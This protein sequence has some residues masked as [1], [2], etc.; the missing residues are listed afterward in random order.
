MD[1]L[2]QGRCENC[3]I[4]QLNSL[5]ALS[6]SELK[7]ISDSKTTKS[8]KKGDTIFTEGENLNGVFCVRNGVTKLSK[9]S[10]NGKD[11]IVKLAKK[12]EVLGQRSVIANQKT[13]L[14]AIALKD[15]EVC[16]IPKHK[17]NESI[18]NNIE[19]TKEILLKM[20][21]ELKFANDMIMDLSQK[22][23]KQRVA[24]ILLYLN[25]S[26]DKDDEGFIGLYLTRNDISDIVGTAKEA[27]IR[28]LTELKNEG[29]IFTQGKRIKILKP[30]SLLHFINGI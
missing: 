7:A 2:E 19:F 11:Q 28:T 15:M 29:F 18:N 13:N 24:Q 30:K 17:L 3:I 21:D 25:N 20:T 1:T 5:K 26:F 4:R 22:T 23:V 10:A 27:C 8:I 14:A 12:G 6:K 9:L 16:F